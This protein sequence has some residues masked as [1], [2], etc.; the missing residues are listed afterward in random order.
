M[1]TSRSSLM[2]LA[3]MAIAGAGIG[4][5][6]V[7]RAQPGSERNGTSYFDSQGRL[8]VESQPVQRNNAPSAIE[9]A[10]GMFGGYRSG[11]RGHQRRAGPGWSNRHVKRM[12]VKA[13]NVKRHRARS[14][15]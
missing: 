5:I 12:A 3:A 6:G 11:S 15:A 2:A 9:R 13:R 1:R 4:H 7:D 14:R 10:L 8:V